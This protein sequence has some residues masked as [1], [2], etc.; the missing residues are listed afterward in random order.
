MYGGWGN[1]GGGV[2]PLRHD[3]YCSPSI[4]VIKLGRQNDGRVVVVHHTTLCSVNQK[5]K[6]HPRLVPA[7]LKVAGEPQ[8]QAL[9]SRFQAQPCY[10]HSCKERPPLLGLPLRGHQDG[11]CTTLTRMDQHAQDQQ[12]QGDQQIEQSPQSWEKASMA[13]LPSTSNRLLNHCAH[14]FH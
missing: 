1:G 9:H 11:P 12:D 4:V 2:V 3:Y 7:R 6:P 8:A 10:L 5:G 13:S 14:A